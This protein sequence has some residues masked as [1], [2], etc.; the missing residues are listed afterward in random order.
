[1]ETRSLSG[2]LAWTA[3]GALLLAAGPAAATN[4]PRLTAY[5]ARA[6][7]RGGVDYGFADDGIGP[8]TNPAGMA[9]AG[10]GNRLDNNW[11]LIDAG[12]EWENSFGSFEDRDNIQFIVPA[13][14]FGAVFDPAASWQVGNIFKLGSWGLDEELTEEEIA[15]YDALTAEERRFGSR[16]KLGFGV[17]PITGGKIQIKDM[18][19]SGFPEPRDWETDSIALAIT[20]SL[21]FRVN[22]FFSVGLN[23]QVIYSTFELDGGIAQPSFLLRD[24]FELADS[25]LNV[26]PQTITFADLDDA[27]T[28]GFSWRIGFQIRPADWVT[29]G[30]IYQDRTYLQ[31]LIGRSTVDATAE[32]NNLTQGNTSLLQLVDPAVDPS[33]GFVSEYDLRIQDYEFPRQFGLGVALRPHPRLSIGLDYTFIQWS[34]TFRQFKVRLSDGDNPNLDIMTRPSIPVRVPLKLRDQH[35]VALGLTV[36]ALEGDD[37]VEGEPSYRLFWRAGYNY[38]GAS[39]PADTTLPQVPIINE[40]H[41][42]TG[43]SLYWGP[44]VELSF[45]FEW[46]I[47]REIQ[48]RDHDGDFTLDDSTQEVGLMLFHFGLGFNF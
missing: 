18:R 7:G 43:F 6:A 23:L 28:F 42:S 47:P 9:F 22:E 40:H 26:R 20:P 45:A 3:A 13:F 32:V 2:R 21:A 38:A 48:T 14:S 46:Q 33:L 12:V 16:W 29:I 19:T 30:L 39:P 35:V 24:D 25:I 44:L 41:V 11:V 36:L 10:Y 34:D 17:F 31:D 37:I 5:G 27:D 15:E 8:W 4:G 1:M